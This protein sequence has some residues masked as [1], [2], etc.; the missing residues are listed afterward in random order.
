MTTQVAADVQTLPD[1]FYEEPEPIEDG[2]QQEPIITL[3]LFILRRWFRGKNVFVGAG[4]F[5]FWNRFDAKEK[6]SPDGIVALDTDPDFIYEFPNYFLWE[7]NKPP[8]VVMEVA[9]PS[10]ASNDLGHKRDVYARLGAREYWKFDPTG[11]DL[12][13]AALMG[14]R[15]VDGEYVPYELNVESDGSMWSRSDVLNLDFYWDGEFF[16]IRDPLTGQ[17]ID[18]AVISE[19]AEE[20]ADTAEERAELERTRADT[21]EG[22]AELERTRADTAEER[23]ELERTRADTERKARLEAEAKLRRLVEERRQDD[24][25]EQPPS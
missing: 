9:S 13:G 20:R 19:L 11:G 17:T 7:V 8:D 4:G 18:P 3:P 15:L 21:A 22:L 1:A 12:Y 5:I 14:E 16:D 23:A 24:D 2:M 6:L 25:G 10:T